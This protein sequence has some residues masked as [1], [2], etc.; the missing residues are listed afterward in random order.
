M[1]WRFGREEKLESEGAEVVDSRV[2]ASD[3]SSH[4]ESDDDEVAYELH[5]WAGE[6]RLVLDQLLTAR[7]VAH[8]WQGAT[9]VVRA[10]DEIEVDAAVDEAEAAANPTL[11]QDAEKVVYETTGWGGDEQTAFSDFLGRLGVAHEFDDHGDLVVEAADEE[12]VET[13]LDAF[14]VM[15]DD[16]PELEGLDANGLLTAVFVACDRLRRDPHDDAGVRELVTLAPILVGH[17]PPFGFV[18]DQWDDLGRR[19]GD[20]VGLLVEG[21]AEET[22]I[23]EE[24]GSLVELLR[25]LV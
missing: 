24:A 13:A 8:V 1:K 19:T 15:L 4:Q 3:G 16:R 14:Q 7:S 12:A 20:L 21:N 5:E 17:R 10:V 22:T 25:T 18:A 6:A 23:S 9:L 11:D 2:V